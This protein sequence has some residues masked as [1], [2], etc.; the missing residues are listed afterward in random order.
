[1]SVV[2]TQASI[3]HTHDSVIHTQVSVRH[4]QASAGEEK[5]RTPEVLVVRPLL[6]NH[7]RVPNSG[8]LDTLRRVS[9]TPK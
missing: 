3:V 9:Y 1:M 7:D 5:E 6:R 4:T 8:E 2:H